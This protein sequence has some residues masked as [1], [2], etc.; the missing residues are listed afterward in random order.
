MSGESQKLLG[1]NHTDPGRPAG[2]GAHDGT[3]IHPIMVVLIG[4]FEAG[5]VNVRAG[6][7]PE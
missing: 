4:K 5:G 6:D 1:T 7:K 3:G 2:G